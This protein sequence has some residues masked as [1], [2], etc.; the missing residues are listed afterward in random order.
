MSERKLV[1][2]CITCS[3]IGIVALFVI[4]S[5]A[6]PL[7]V[8]P[9]G[10]A[11]LDARSGNSPMIKVAGFVDSVSIAESRAVVKIAELETVE[12]VSFDAGYI[13]GLG[14]KRFQEVEVFG[15]LREYKGRASVIVAKIRVLNG[16][17]GSSTP[18]LST[19]TSCGCG[20]EFGK[21]D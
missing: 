3:A 1:V 14:L 13:K 11:K 17:K 9:S 16:N 18:P 21:P 2:L 15:E 4:A 12:A 20:E 7:Q 19:L 10:A 8:S 6:G 5:V